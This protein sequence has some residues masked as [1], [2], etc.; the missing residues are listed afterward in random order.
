[1]TSRR[2][3]LAALLAGAVLTKRVAAA[4]PLPETDREPAAESFDPL[5]IPNWEGSEFIAL[6]LYEGFTALDVFGPHHLFKLLVGAKVHLVAQTLDPVGADTGVRVVPTAT[7][8]DCP[9][10]MTVL[11][12]PGG[13]TARSKPPKIRL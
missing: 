7:F 13:S 2:E 5:A 8:A 10:E 11:C 3:L 4:D 9:R 12:V 6:P 1:M